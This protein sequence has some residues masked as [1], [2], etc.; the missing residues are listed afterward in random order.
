MAK[1]T[2]R[3]AL[4]A[5]SNEFVK[6]IEHLIIE[7]LKSNTYKITMGYINSKTSKKFG[8]KVFPTDDIGD[9]R[10]FTEFAK[11]FGEV[12]PLIG[13]IVEYNEDVVE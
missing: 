8:C 7:A 2:K 1:Y 13:A 12:S 6:E 4:I 11:E 3:V 10:I 9:M 5:T